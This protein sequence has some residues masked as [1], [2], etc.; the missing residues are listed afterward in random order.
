MALA[1]KTPVRRLESYKRL[2]FHVVQTLK[3]I[4]VFHVV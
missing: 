3:G 2:I 1:E 4:Y